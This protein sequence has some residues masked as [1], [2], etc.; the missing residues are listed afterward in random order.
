M[1]DNGLGRLGEF[2]LLKAIGRR[3]AEIR[4]EARYHLMQ[5]AFMAIIIMVGTITL[6]LGLLTLY[7][8]LSERMSSLE[9]AAWMTGGFLLLT[10]FLW[11]TSYLLPFC[12]SKKQTVPIGDQKIPQDATAALLTDITSMIVEHPGKAS[13]A[14]LVAG[15]VVGY[16]PEVRIVLLKALDEMKNQEKPEA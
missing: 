11:L 14:A 6:I 16:F 4:S 9:A 3:S 13:L 12:R 8:Y 2:I 1:A 7:I 5:A 10:I 15:M